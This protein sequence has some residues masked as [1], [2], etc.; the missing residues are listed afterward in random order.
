MAEWHY[1]L[2]LVA[3]G[4]VDLLALQ[5]RLSRDLPV[6][7]SPSAKLLMWGTAE[8]DRID[9]WTDHTPTQL[10]A[11]FDLRTPSE[12]F[13][14]LVLEVTREFQLRLVNAEDAAVEPTDAALLADLAASEAQAFVLSP[15]AEEDEE[16]E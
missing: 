2:F 7:A 3:D 11:R 10:L 5:G 14:R 12:G 13:R 15:P 8:G 16:E 1:N 4:P 6:M 9:F